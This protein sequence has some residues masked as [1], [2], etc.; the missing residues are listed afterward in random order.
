MLI[1]RD[2]LEMEF[3]AFWVKLPGMDDVL[4][5]FSCSK[6]LLN[7]NNSNSS[8]SNSSSHSLRNKNRNNNNNDNNSLLE[9]GRFFLFF[10]RD[11]DNKR[12]RP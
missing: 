9:A 7:M 8:H 6:I 4:S 1:D 3:F 11:L 12:R 5:C 2:E 10:P